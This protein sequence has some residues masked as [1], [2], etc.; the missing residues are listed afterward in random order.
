MT[1]WVA[2]A[3]GPV[4]HG[5]VSPVALQLMHDSGWAAGSHNHQLSGVA[6]A[7]PGSRMRSVPATE[8][9]HQLP[10]RCFAS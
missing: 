6:S 7:T 8:S 9:P 5:P 2:G 4:P 10:D 1:E 3:L